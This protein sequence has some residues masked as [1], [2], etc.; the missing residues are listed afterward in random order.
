MSKLKLAYDNQK[1]GIP[2]VMPLPEST[3]DLSN[4]ASSRV[5]KASSSGTQSVKAFFKVEEKENAEGGPNKKA[6]KA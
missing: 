6:R 1:A 3:S 5:Y 4:T 2:L